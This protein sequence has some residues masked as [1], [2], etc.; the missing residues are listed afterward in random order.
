MNQIRI[1]NLTK[2]FGDATVLDDVTVDFEAGKIYGLTGR[3]GSGKTM[4]L[5]CICGLIIPTH[6]TVTIDGTVVDGAI[7]E[8]IKMGI[9]IESPG[10]LR[11]YSGIR[12][13]QL[14]AM[15]QEKVDKEDI[16]QSMKLV[17]LD[18]DSKKKVGK[19]SMGMKQRLGIAQA[20][21][22]NPE[23]LLL[24]EPMNGLDDASVR[25]IRELLL[26]WKSHDKLI[27]L[28]SHSKEDIGFLCDEVY[29]MH[30]GKIS[31]R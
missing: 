22:G 21:M 31:R 12:N 6:G 20:I 15:V 27:I 7:A 4:L 1:R 10:F 28:A 13:L 9:I 23:I 18:P 3:N 19:Y 5:K 24:D 26:K 25:C 17:G 11:D 30:S 8:D 29:E 2:K 16:I 14:L